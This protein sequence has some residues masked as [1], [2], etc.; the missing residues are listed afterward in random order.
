[1]RV[2]N[3]S[4][5]MIDCEAEFFRQG[6][7]KVRMRRSGRDRIPCRQLRLHSRS[8]EGRPAVRPNAGTPGVMTALR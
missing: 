7:Y 2:F 3:E 8:V 4:F 6:L 5:D 1:M